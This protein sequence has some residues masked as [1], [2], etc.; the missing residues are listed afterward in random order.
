MD[1]YE[2]S[3]GI[4]EYLTQR[5]DPASG[6]KRAGI[7]ALAAAGIAAGSYLLIKLNVTALIPVLAVAIVFLVTRLWRYTSAEY[8][9]SLVDSELRVDV[10]YGKA[11]RREMVRVEL[12]KALS[13]SPCDGSDPG[14]AQIFDASSGNEERW[15]IIYSDDKNRKCA[16]IIDGPERVVAAVRRANPRIFSAQANG[17]RQ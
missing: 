4:T 9:Y 3:L 14:A 5:R 7:V 8:E 13:V 15:R 2:S 11:E 12:K 1:N 17:G 10:I 16:L 6:A